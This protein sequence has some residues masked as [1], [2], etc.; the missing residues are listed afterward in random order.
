MEKR[1]GRNRETNPSHY[2]YPIESAVLDRSLNWTSVFQPC[3]NLNSSLVLL[4]FTLSRAIKFPPRSDEAVWW[5][6]FGGISRIV[7]TILVGGNDR[8]VIHGRRQTDEAK[9]SGRVE[10]FRFD[11]AKSMGST[12]RR[13]SVLSSPRLL[14]HRTGKIRIIG[15]CTGEN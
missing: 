4:L 6:R 5:T 15:F 13:P 10:R 3:F 7:T 12:Y 11:T 1:V 14:F 2:A 8:Q 9:K